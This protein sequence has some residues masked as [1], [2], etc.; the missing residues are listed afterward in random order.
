[1][2]NGGA[3]TVHAAIAARRSI[4][5]YRP[6]AV[7]PALLDRLLQAAVMAPSAHH[8]QP[9]RFVRLREP[10]AK[11]ALAEAMGRRLAEDRA[12][13]GD[14]E[15]AIRRDVERS[16]ARITGAPQLVLVCLTLEE[17]DPY[18][19]RRRA[20]AEYLMAVQ[21]TAMAAQNLLLAAEAEGL[22]ACWMC[23]PLFCPDTV[24]AAL[25]LPEAWQPQGLITLGWPAATGRLRPRKPLDVVAVER[26][27][28]FVPSSRPLQN[29]KA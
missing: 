10:A 18:P 29:A 20:E 17:M 21:S 11:A 7:P 2:T 3:A 1:M 19:D 22:A 8:R 28:L 16:A 15:A 4:R 14:P 6:E 13:D 5:A 9:W 24:R 23:A 26:D 27:S 12:R 25:A